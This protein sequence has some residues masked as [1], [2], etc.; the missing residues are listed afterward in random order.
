MI[1]TI[2]TG[3]SVVADVAEQPFHDDDG[4][5]EGHPEADRDFPD[6]RKVENIAVLPQVIGE[7]RSHRRDRQKEAEL[8][9][10]R[11]LDPIRS[12]PTMVAPERE[13][14]GI[15]ARHWMNP[16]ASAIGSGKRSASAWRGRSGNR[17]TIRRM[18]PPDDEHRRD[19]R[20]FRTATCLMMSCARTPITIA[21][22]KARST[23]PAK[24]RAIGSVGSAATVETILPKYTPTMARIARAG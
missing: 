16:I 8:A 7:G 17:S 5:K 23:D 21:G 18:T 12:A 13:T 15:I 10:A 19:Q 11:L 2:R 3:E 1:A 20:G 14:P 6:R 4:R 22:R 24:R 9:A